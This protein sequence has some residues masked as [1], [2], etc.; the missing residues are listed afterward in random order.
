MGLSLN[1][2]SIWGIPISGNRRIYAYIYIYI[3]ANTSQEITY[4]TMSNQDVNSLDEEFP[5][6]FSIISSR[7]RNLS[8]SHPRRWLPSGMGQAWTSGDLT[9]E[10]GL[11]G[12]LMGFDGIIVGWNGTT[13]WWT[14]IT[15]CE[16]ENHHL[17]WVNELFPWAVFNCELSNY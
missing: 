4:H 7:S 11:M 6:C 15:V 2:P 10:R 8:A 9:D 3:L 16:L 17:Q 14:N 5:S 1:K 12:C 13:F